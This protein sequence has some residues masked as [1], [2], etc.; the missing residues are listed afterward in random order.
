MQGL[1][2]RNPGLEVCEL[3]TGKESSKIQRLCKNAALSRKH[4]DHFQFTPLV[5][6]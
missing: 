5:S 1:Q 2:E 6:F 4:G 3:R